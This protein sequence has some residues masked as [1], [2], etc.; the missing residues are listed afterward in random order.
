MIPSHIGQSWGVE[1][2][3]YESGSAMLDQKRK[4]SERLKDPKYVD[5]TV[6]L[7]LVQTK[8]LSHVKL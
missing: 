2:G 7:A 8:Q 1:L 3:G 6:P 4:H 5:T